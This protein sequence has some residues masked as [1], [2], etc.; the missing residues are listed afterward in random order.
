MNTAG[1]AKTRKRSGKTQKDMGDMKKPRRTWENMK[2]HPERG[3][4]PLNMGKHPPTWFR[5]VLDTPCAKPFIILEGYHTILGARLQRESGK[6]MKSRQ[7]EIGFLHPNPT[8]WSK[9][10]FCTPNMYFLSGT[11]FPCLCM[12]IDAESLFAHVHGHAF[13]CPLDMIPITNPCLSDML[14]ACPST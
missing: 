6:C 9:M 2:R 3:N 5:A 12:T 8:F 10:L 11:H 1:H 14:F 7:R 13:P 4:T